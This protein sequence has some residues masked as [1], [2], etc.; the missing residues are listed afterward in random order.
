MQNLKKILLRSSAF[1]ENAMIPKKY[2]GQ[3]VNVNPPLA[4]EN[5]PNE[6]KSLALIVDDP[7]APVGLWTHWL[8][9]NIP[10]DTK[11][12]EENSIPGE[13]IINSW[14]KKGWGGPMPPSGT[15]RYFFKLYA[16]D[17]DNIKANTKNQ[18]YKEVEKHKIAEGHLIGL[19]KTIN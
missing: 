19:Y 6:T 4:W 13:E 5:I 7:D 11:R 10:K 17:I 16:L 14:E 1:A 18:F 3:G 8:V 9:K 15:H 12:I 2:T